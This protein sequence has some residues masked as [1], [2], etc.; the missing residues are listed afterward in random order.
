MR[1]LCD[2]NGPGPVLCIDANGLSSD[3]PG[4]GGV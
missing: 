4:G 3:G 1:R 2:A